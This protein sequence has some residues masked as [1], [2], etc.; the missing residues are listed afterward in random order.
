MDRMANMAAFTKVLG[1]SFSAAAREMQVSQA[2]VITQIR[3][4]E[5]WLGRAAAQRYDRYPA[6]R[7][8]AAHKGLQHALPREIG[9]R[10]SR[11]ADRCDASG[12]NVLHHRDDPGSTLKIERDDLVT[13]NERLSSRIVL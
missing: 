1:G 3:K 9:R 6:L 11:K 8:P 7:T 5:S 2:L 12:R 13:L 10:T 4:L